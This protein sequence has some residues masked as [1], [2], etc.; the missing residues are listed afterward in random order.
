MTVF[1]ANLR[2]TEVVPSMGW[3]TGGSQSGTKS[4]QGLSHPQRAE[5][6]GISLSFVTPLR[7]HCRWKG[8]RVYLQQGSGYHPDCSQA[9]LTIG[10]H[11]AHNERP[12]SASRA[13]K[14]EVH[15]YPMWICRRVVCTY[16]LRVHR[17]YTLY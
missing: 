9:T 15:T 6:R 17:V 3:V 10:K 16:V 13:L 7:P 1:G 12:E 14:E 2:L 11:P 4:V 8:V 5:V